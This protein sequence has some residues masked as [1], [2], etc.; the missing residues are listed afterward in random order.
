MLSI[1]LSRIEITPPIGVEITGHPNYLL[2]S[3]S[4][5]RDR[6]WAKAL[7]IESRQGLVLLVTMDCMWI[8]E[9]I[10]QAIV[11]AAGQAGI[12]EENVLVAASHTHSGPQTLNDDYALCGG[13]IA[14][15][16]WN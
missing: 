3:Y 6:L 13:P 1:R 4:Q 8:S 14:P 9:E 7:L 5:V 10:R 11:H 2:E 15:T 16:F 12:S